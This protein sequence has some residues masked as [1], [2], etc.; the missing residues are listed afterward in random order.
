MSKKLV[1]ILITVAFVVGIVGGGVA[2]RYYCRQFFTLFY[3]SM[4]K[5]HANSTLVTLERLRANNVTN[6]IELLE[7]NLD[8]SIILLD[9]TK[10]YVPKSER[11]K[12]LEFLRK[13]KEYRVRFPRKSEDSEYNQEVSNVLSHV[14]IEIKK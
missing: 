4:E 10:D 3:S 12:E 11:E 7:V 5:S 13:A 8:G 2:D 1:V 6:S 9:T 14:E